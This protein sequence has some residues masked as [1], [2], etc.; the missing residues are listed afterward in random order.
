M[1]TALRLENFK[2]FRDATLPL[3]AFTLVVGTNASGK[4]NLLDAF[5]LL[6]GLSRGYSLSEVLGEK[7]GPGGEL[8]WNGIR[9]GAIELGFRGAEKT[10]IHVFEDENSLT[11]SIPNGESKNAR[12]EERSSGAQGAAFSRWSHLLNR[13]GER[14]G[15]IGDGPWK[16]PSWL[17]ELA[18]QVRTSHFFDLHPESMRRPSIP[19]S[20]PLGQRG[21]NLSSVLYRLCEDPEQKANLLSWLH[22]LTPSDVVDL[23]FPQDFTGRILLRLIEKDG[24]R[25]TAASASDGTLRFLALAAALLT[26]ENS[27]FFLEEIDT[28]IH[29]TRLH[30][31]V[32]LIERQC[33][34]RGVQVVATTH[35]PWMLSWL[36]PASLA[37]AVVVYR[38]AQD[39]S[40]RIRRICDL[41]DIQRVLERN[42]LAT[43]H[44]EGWLEQAVA[45]AD[46]GEDSA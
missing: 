25:F 23:D 37:S 35:A 45:F 31:L 16:I 11:V 6:H 36:G 26:A 20:A 46:E 15:L 32:Q 14:D 4:S 41:P 27:L 22:E 24:T 40:S 33:A 43:L 5:R 44:A 17:V 19:G 8:V 38:G 34:A 9:G 18:A 42:E 30:L 7:Y 28:G 13:A 2:S 21:E 3:G 12:L 1:I 29:P 10:S 39:G